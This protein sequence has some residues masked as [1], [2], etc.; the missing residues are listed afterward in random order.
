MEQNDTLIY[1]RLSCVRLCQ[2][3][4]IFLLSTALLEGCGGSDDSVGSNGSGDDPQQSYYDQLWDIAKESITPDMSDDEIAETLAR[5][6]V[7]NS[8]NA[9]WV[10]EDSIYPL[11][12][13]A[14]GSDDALLPFHGLCGDRSLLFE[15][16]CQRA[17]LTVSVFNMYNFSGPGHGHTCAQVY[18]DDDWHFYDVTYAGMFIANGEVLS[19]SEMRADPILA[20]AGMAVFEP[21]GDVRDYYSSGLPVDNSERMQVVYTEEALVNAISTSFLGSGNL[22]PLKVLFDLSNL[23]IYVGDLAGTSS[24][25]DNDGSSQSI[26]NCLG[27]MLGYVWDNFEPVIT[28]T[29]AVPGESYSIKFFIYHST[30]PGLFFRV[31]ST[32]GVN[33]I[34]GSELTTSS[35]MLWPETSVAWEITFYAEAEEASFTIHH[36]CDEGHGL[37][38]NYI[39]VE[40]GN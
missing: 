39:A 5:W 29:N 34:S 33:I 13:G 27:T 37:F 16:F 28:L 18:Y 4:I 40:V 36:D 17:G 11:P 1:C 9:R 7:S 31:I 32:N 8:T 25:L 35:E 24:D 6:I 3:L 14:R 20:L 30:E 12:E 23:P 19:F 10:S 26:S 21:T 15:Y 38:L 22:V 2:I